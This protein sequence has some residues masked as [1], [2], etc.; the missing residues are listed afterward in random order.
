MVRQLKRTSSFLMQIFTL[1]KPPYFSVKTGHTRSHTGTRNN[2]G[3]AHSSCTSESKEHSQNLSTIISFLSIIGRLILK[4]YIKTKRSRTRHQYT[5]A[6]RVPRTQLSLR[7]DTKMFL[8]LFRFPQIYQLITN[9]LN[10]CQLNI[11][12]SSNLWRI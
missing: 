5:S 1:Q 4:Q 3:Q 12:I 10:Q 9:N 11:L 7:Q 8:C 2:L 6:S